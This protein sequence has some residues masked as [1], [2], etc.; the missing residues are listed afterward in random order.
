MVAI[1]GGLGAAMS[2]AIATL[3]SSRSS[4]MIGA[5]SV[6][7]WVMAVGLVAAIVPAMLATPV[8]LDAL[9]VVELVTLGLSHNLGL[10]LAYRALS[11]G[12]VSIV[13]PITAT[14]GAA[15]ALISVVL[16]ETRGIVS[17]VFLAVIALGVVLAAAERAADKPASQ[18]SNEQNR[19]AALYALAAAVVFSVGLVLGG[20]LGAAGVPPAWVIVAS[21]TVGVMIIVLPLVLLG[22][23]RITRPALPLVVLSGLLEAIGSA[24]YVIAASHGVA[25]AA[26]L[27]SQFAAFAAIGGFLLFGE[28][29]Q[30]LQLVGVVVIAIGIT[31]LSALQA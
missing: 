24:V 17:A 27:S 4:R 18:V 25:V 11:I 26:V 21:R 5:P 28:R 16:G 15:A 9:K 22:R 2:W 6:L 14:E 1:L 30:R 29:L 10:L 23:F 3:A 12:Q 31:T 7:G 19:K 20:K 13:A 8:A